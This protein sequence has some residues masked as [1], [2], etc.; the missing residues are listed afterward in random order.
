MTTGENGSKWNTH[1]KMLAKGAFNTVLQ[2]VWDFESQE[3]KWTSI[4]YVDLLAV[5]SNLEWWCWFSS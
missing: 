4:Q 3:N 2:S 5:A 1:D